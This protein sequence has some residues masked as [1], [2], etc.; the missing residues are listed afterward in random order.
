MK[1]PLQP[2]RCNHRQGGAQRHSGHQLWNHLYPL[3][4]WEE[5]VAHSL[6]G[7]VGSKYSMCY[8]GENPM[9]SLLEA[10]LWTNRPL[11][12]LPPFLTFFWGRQTW[13]GLEATQY[14][15]SESGPFSSQPLPGSSRLPVLLW[16]DLR[17]YRPH[18]NEQWPLAEVTDTFLQERQAGLQPTWHQVTDMHLT[19]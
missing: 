14:R 12:C 4:E 8:F 13:K 9:S 15:G 11:A 5:Q 7:G 3:R 6:L 2:K 17:A 19:Y 18:S 10:W 1:N 16:D